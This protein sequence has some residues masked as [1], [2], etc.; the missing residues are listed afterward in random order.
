[1]AS[2]SDF[3]ANFQLV[4][5]QVDELNSYREEAMRILKQNEL[6]ISLVGPEALPVIALD[7]E[8]AH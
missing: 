8:T 6:K 3:I 7:L 5:K 4:H 1:M 2:Y